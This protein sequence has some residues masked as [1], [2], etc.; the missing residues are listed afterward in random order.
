MKGNITHIVFVDKDQNLF[1]MPNSLF[2]CRIQG[3]KNTVV[4]RLEEPLEFGDNIIFTVEHPG[5][6]IIY[7]YEKDINSFKTEVIGNNY[8]VTF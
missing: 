6:H 3:A 4:A 1:D 2:K 5:S 7:D 8:L